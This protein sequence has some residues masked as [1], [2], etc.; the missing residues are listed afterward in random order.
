VYPHGTESVST[1][2]MRI[3]IESLRKEVRASVPDEGEETYFPRPLCGAEKSGGNESHRCYPI[4]L[5]RV[6]RR[7]CGLSHAANGQELSQRIQ[8]PASLT[9][10]QRQGSW[11]DA[12]PGGIGLL[13][14]ERSMAIF[15]ISTNEL[16]ALS[17]TS[18]GAENL[19]ERKDIQRLLRDHIS[20]LDDGQVRFM[21]VAQEFR[22]WLDSS[23]RIDLLCIDSEANLVVVEL[24]RSDDG[25]YM[26]LQALRYA[27]MVSQITFEELVSTFARYKNK[28]QPDTEAARSA[29]LKFIEWEIVNEEEFAQETRIVLAAADFGKELTTT[30]LWLRDQHRID[31]RCVRMKPWRMENGTLLLDVQQLSP[32]PE[33]R[34]F[35]TQADSRLRR[36]S[37]RQSPEQCP[38]GAVLRF[39]VN[40]PGLTCGARGTGRDR[41]S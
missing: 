15:Q 41:C 20:V 26:E 25:G 30:V 14:G 9:V 3:R 12:A 13:Q 40:G 35:Q 28:A 38:S 31:I 21:V 23:R 1:I 16:K 29:I 7:H 19:L 37:R 6:C 5:P 10:C 22:D 4:E 24:K 34:D 33:T 27:A 2:P 39:A 36:H 18:F 17:E 11:M 32:R 8:R